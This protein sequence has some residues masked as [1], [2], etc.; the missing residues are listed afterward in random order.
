MWY[1]ED[2]QSKLQHNNLEFKEKREL[3]ELSNELDYTFYPAIFS[4]HGF[5]HESSVE[6]IKIYASNGDH[7]WNIEIFSDNT[8]LI[9]YKYYAYGIIFNTKKDLI[10]RV[11]QLFLD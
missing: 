8:I 2:S 5:A 9:N 1:F 10:D 6:S 4:N 7:A 11:K 3:I